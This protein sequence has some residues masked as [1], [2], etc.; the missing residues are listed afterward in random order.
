M[1]LGSRHYGWPVDRIVMHEEDSD[2]KITRARKTWILF[3]AA[4]E[5]PSLKKYSFQDT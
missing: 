1:P 3:M 5:K 2:G 4:V